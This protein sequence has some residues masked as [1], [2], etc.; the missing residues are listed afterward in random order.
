MQPEVGKRPVM[1][2][3]I[4][5]PTKTTTKKQRVT[6]DSL[7][8]IMRREDGRSTSIKECYPRILYPAKIYLKNTGK[9]K[10][11]LVASHDK[12]C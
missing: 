10:A 7:S 5:P 6:A 9:K 1:Y 8:E 11:L 12:K 4:T 2:R 3:G